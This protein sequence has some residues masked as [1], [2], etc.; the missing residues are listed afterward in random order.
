MFRYVPELLAWAIGIVL[1]V[2]MVQRGGAGLEKL[3]LAGCSL[4]F[5]APLIGVLLNNWLNRLI[6]EQDT[7]YIEAVQ[8]PL[9]IALSIAIALLSLAGLVCLVW[10]FFARFRTKK[11][12][13]E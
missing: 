1:A 11:Q 12:E 3:L 6:Q 9:W 8:S 10:A 7:S 2:I 4:M 13:A 5:V